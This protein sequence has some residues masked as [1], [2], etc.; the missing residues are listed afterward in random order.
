MVNGTKDS[1]SNDSAMTTTT[2]VTTYSTSYSPLDIADCDDWHTNNETYTINKFP[3]VTSLRLVSALVAAVLLVAVGATVTT[4][5][6]AKAPTNEPAAA[7]ANP[8]SSSSQSEHISIAIVK[9]IPLTPLATTP[10][11]PSRATE[12]TEYIDSI[13]LSDGTLAV[14]VTSRTN[15][16]TSEEAALAWLIYDDP[17]QLL[18]DSETNQ[19]RLKFATPS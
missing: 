10:P 3:K 17:L 16:T 4:L 8:S 6:H 14:P 19:F 2:A 12:V 1:S 11:V 13:K 9:T 7:V 18:P 5:R 15:S